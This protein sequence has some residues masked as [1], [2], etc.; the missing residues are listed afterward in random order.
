[1]SLRPRSLFF[2]GVEE[3]NVIKLVHVL[4]QLLHKVL[5]YLL[6]LPFDLP[7]FVNDLAFKFV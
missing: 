5:I 4:L 2:I 7:S 6:K 3:L 1:M